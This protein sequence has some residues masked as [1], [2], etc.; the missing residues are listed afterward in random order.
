MLTIEASRTNSIPVLAA[1]LLGRLAARDLERIPLLFEPEADLRALQPDG[2]LVGEGVEDIAGMFAMWF[3]DV[4]ELELIDST[5]GW[6]GSRV[7]VRWL[8]RVRGDRFGSRPRLIE[9][10]AYGII[11]PTNR[12]AT[13]S[14]V[15]SGYLLEPIDG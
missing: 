5:S 4:D 6:I 7:Q 9:Q 8:V 3:G 2:L 10:C 12:F 14:L 13:M 15:C 11:G 1:Q